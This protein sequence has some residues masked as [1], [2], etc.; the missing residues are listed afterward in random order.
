VRA[1]KLSHNQ[2]GDC[3]ALELA[4]AL[5]NVE[6]VLADAQSGGGLLR[7]V[8][9]WGGGGGGGQVEC[10]FDCVHI[11]VCVCVYIYMC[12]CVYVYVCMHMY[13]SVEQPTYKYICM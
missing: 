10:G 7:K 12:V 2:I 8:V 13:I 3:G 5:S 4:L 1:L 6:C 9:V 11:F